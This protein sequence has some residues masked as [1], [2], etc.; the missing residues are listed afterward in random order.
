MEETNIIGLFVEDHERI[1][2]LLNDFKKHKHN[3][4]RKTKELFSQLSRSIAV[5][6]H[7]EEI[8]Y[9]QYRNTTGKTL[10][11]LQT[12]RNEHTLISEKIQ[13]IK[14]ELEKGE[15]K[16]EIG[17]LYEVIERHKNVE[18]RL[19]YPEL[20]NVLTQKEKDE[21]FWKLKVS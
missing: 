4:A 18:E 6:L 3:R 2:S 5:H 19:L 9:T 15:G 14:D 10:P 11:I 1:S 8:L 20:D 7:Q 12:I 21:V 13:E 16:I 17:D